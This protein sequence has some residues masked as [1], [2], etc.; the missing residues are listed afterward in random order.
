MDAQ[1]RTFLH[2]AGGPKAR[3]GRHDKDTNTGAI[4]EGITGHVTSADI[5]FLELGFPE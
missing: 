4:G 1:A 3:G 5:M 2:G